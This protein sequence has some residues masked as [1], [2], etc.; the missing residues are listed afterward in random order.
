[1]LQLIFLDQ[2]KK[3]R[4]MSVFEKLD[5]LCKNENTLKYVF[6]FSFII[7]QDPWCADGKHHSF[8]W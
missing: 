6:E 7:D 5:F 4:K 3:L 1:M 2:K 8:E